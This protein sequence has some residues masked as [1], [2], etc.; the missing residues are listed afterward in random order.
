[1]HVILGILGAVITILVLINRLSDAGIDIGW[2]NPF[3]WRR[4]RNY[5][6]NHDLAT[7]FKLDSPL[8]VA[9]LLLVGV[10]KI[11]GD[12]TATQKRLILSVFEADFHQNSKQASDLLA[13]SVHHIGDG[14]D[15]Y[16]NPQ[17]AIAK[18]KDQFSPEQVDSI[19]QLIVKVAE[20][21]APTSLSQKKFIR[22]VEGALPK[23]NK[24]TW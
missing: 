12:L 19:K 4:R 14:K 9:A 2:L 8:D 5:R 16:A 6:L 3:A 23:N 17:K 24:A 18:C 11:D 13:S 22:A 1:M 7:A 21:D 20:I 10:A 15:F